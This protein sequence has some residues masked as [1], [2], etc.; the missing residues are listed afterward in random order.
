M[1]LEQAK[2][3]V[4]AISELN[5]S[6]KDLFFSIRSTA[7]EAAT[8]KQLWREGNKSRLIKIGFTI[9]M[10]PEPTPISEIIGTGIMAAGAIQQVIKNRELYVE[11]IPKTLKKALRELHSSKDELTSLRFQ[12]L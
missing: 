9:F 6:G 12:N 4:K 5:Q 1:K 2:N 11:D 10:L 8:T 3:S 7:Q